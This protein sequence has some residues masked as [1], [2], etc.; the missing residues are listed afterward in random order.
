MH[1]KIVP[2]EARIT[3]WKMRAFCSSLSIEYNTA[4]L[5]GK[6]KSQEGYSDTT[7]LFFLPNSGASFTHVPRMLSDFAN[8]FM[9]LL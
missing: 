7:L 3:E 8:A 6:F 9:P 4:T 5:S 1:R 2:L